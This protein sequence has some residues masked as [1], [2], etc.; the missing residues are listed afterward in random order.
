M[1]A[2]KQQS[3]HLYGIDGLKGI[4]ACIVA[5]AWHYQHFKPQNGSPFY[6]FITFS[7]KYG[8]CMV[9][10]FFMLSGFGMMIGYGDRIINSKINF[11]EFISKRIKKLYPIF[12]FGTVLTIILEIIHMNYTDKTFVYGNF[13]I[14][15]LF[16]NLLFIQD[17]Y[18]GIEWSLD[19]PSW[20]IS[21][22]F[23][24]YILF[25]FVLYKLK[26]ETKVYYAFGAL[27]IVG[28]AVIASKINMP[29]INLLI[30]RGVACFSIGVVLSC[31]Y[32]NRSKFRSQKLGYM[33][34][35]IA[36]A[37]YVIIRFYPKYT[38]DFRMAFILGM[39][40][41]IVLCTVLLPWVN[42]CLG[43]LPLRYLGQISIGIYL[44]HFPV[45]CFLRDVELIRDVPFNYSG[46][47]M[48]LLY[49][50]LVIVSASIYRF[51]IQKWYEKMV[52]DCFK[53]KK[54]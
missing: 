12:L 7:Y 54:K 11:K 44:L 32:K 8:W 18:I 38:G 47:K 46:R 24:C 15:H 23:F 53:L 50:V 49:V 40:P 10:L 43:L 30:G 16:M 45:Q 9:E 6:D 1:Q 17:G 27:S 13:D 52:C 34:L 48:W 2:K 37:S 28:L 35:F 25:Y 51:L 5:F 36:A 29:L 31:I 4:G 3:Q 42:K 41:A 20:C 33:C 26:D 39:A 21:I 14:Q 22:C 19:S